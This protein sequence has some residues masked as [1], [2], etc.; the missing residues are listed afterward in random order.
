MSEFS[1]WPLFSDDEVTAV[2]EVLLSGKVNYWTGSECSNFENEFAVWSRARYAVSLANGTVALEVALRAFDVGKGDEVIVTPRTFIASVSSIVNVGATPVFA[3]FDLK[4]QNITPRSIRL[5]T[6]NKTKAVICVHLAGWPCEMDEIMDL[7]NEFGF[8]VVEDC[9]QAH[10]AKYKGRPV[11]AIG[12]IGCWSFCQDKI[13]TT[14]GEGG[15]VT[16]NNKDLWCKVW[17]YKDYGKSCE[18]S[19]KK[20]ASSGGFNWL[21]NSFGSNFRMTEMQATIGRVQLKKMPDWHKRRLD[22]S[23]KIWNAAREC[24][25]FRVPSTPEYIEYAAYK[26]YIFVEPS[27]LKSGWDRD[28]ITQHI[29]QMGV[30]CYSGSCPEVYLEKVF[31]NSGFK[32]EKRLT[33]AQ[34]LGETSLMFLVHPSLTYQ[35]LEKTINSIKV[36][37]SQATY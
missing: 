14:G 17:S 11:G 3:D 5:A 1:P 23:D 24:G 37:A 35:E 15:M 9:A 36:I 4:S 8:Y 29:F 19:F 32:P 7:S 25:G 31:E 28:K 30:P 10:G 18:S 22:F 2:Q 21:H 34:Y 33:N 27:K 16:T 12:H 13:M 20:K 6:T 26:C